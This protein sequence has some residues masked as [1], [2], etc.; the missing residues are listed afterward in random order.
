MTP[1]G[2]EPRISVEE[3][4]QTYALDSAAIGTDLPQLV[5][6]LFSDLSTAG[7]C[8]SDFKLQRAFLN[9]VCLRSRVGACSVQDMGK[10]V[11]TADLLRTLWKKADVAYILVRH[12]P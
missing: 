5:K 4:P 8:E 3:R 2:F 12:F 6:L 11:D 10:C 1:V 7:R 9:T